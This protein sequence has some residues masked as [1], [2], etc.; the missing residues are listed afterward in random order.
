MVYL[1]LDFGRC[2]DV[3]PAESVCNRKDQCGKTSQSCVRGLC[4]NTA[5]HANAKTKTL[6]DTESSCP[7]SVHPRQIQFS[8]RCSMDT[9]C[10]FQKKCCPTCIG[11]RCLILPVGSCPKITV[12]GEPK[13][14]Q[15]RRYNDGHR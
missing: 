14:R 13:Q 6:T 4:C 9:D 12:S 8:R 3:L 5:A 1:Q 11:R 15:H 7:R 2:A 10:H